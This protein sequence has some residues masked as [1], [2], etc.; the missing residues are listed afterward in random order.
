[1]STNSVRGA[2]DLVNRRA[3]DTAALG[4]R[5]EQLAAAIIL[6]AA[7]ALR[8]VG[9][10]QERLWDDEVYSATWAVQPV[11]D[12]VIAALR[13]DPHMP[14]YYLQFHM[15]ALISHS[16]LW[17]YLNSLLW[18]WFAVFALWYCSRRFLAPAGALCATLLFVAMPVGVWWSHNL[19]MYGMLG[20]LSILAWF[21]CY[22]LFTGSSF[23][24]DGLFLGVGSVGNGL[25]TRVRVLVFRICWRLRALFD[26]TGETRVEQGLVV[27]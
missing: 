6:V 20:C 13:F 5:Q 14:L 11:F 27:D 23:K 18:S 2:A 15:W 22:R 17:L 7:L 3:G 25:F 19:R 24:R 10:P 21:F 12:I 8:G 4:A 16:T 26:W 9:L 1:M